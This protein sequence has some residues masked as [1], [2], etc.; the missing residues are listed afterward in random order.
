MQLTKETDPS[1]FSSF[2]VLYCILYVLLP[3]R[4]NKRFINLAV[5][6]Y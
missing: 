1:M 2:S 5:S 6:C 3:K 4:Q